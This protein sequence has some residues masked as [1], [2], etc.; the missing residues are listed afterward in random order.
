MSKPELQFEIRDAE[1]AGVIMRRAYEA[2][3]KGLAAGS[4][5]VTLGRKKRS[6]DQNRKLW[7]MLSGVSCLTPEN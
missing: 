2:V 6:L 1:N 4:V 3:K 7:P 5:V